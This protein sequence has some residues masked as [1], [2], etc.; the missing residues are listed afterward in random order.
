MYMIIYF[1]SKKIIKYY[2]GWSAEAQEWEKT[3]D[4]KFFIKIHGKEWTNKNKV[5]NKNSK[6]ADYKDKYLTPFQWWFGF[7]KSNIKKVTEK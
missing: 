5:E 2:V 3:W 7:K 6:I 4:I 1:G